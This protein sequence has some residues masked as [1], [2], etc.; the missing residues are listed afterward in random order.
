MDT[1]GSVTETVPVGPW[2]WLASKAAREQYA[3]L[4]AR[5]F[6]PVPQDSMDTIIRH[7]YARAFFPPKPRPASTPAGLLHSRWSKAWEWGV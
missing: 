5:W 7:R 1:G 4:T 6:V 3:A 2:P